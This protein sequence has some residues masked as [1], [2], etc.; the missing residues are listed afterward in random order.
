MAVSR[1][2][3][4]QITINN[5]DEHEINSDVINKI[6]KEISWQYYCFAYEIGEQEHTPHI[7]LYFVCTNAVSFDR[8]KKLF[9]C[10]HLEACKGTS[11][12][13]RNYIRKEGKHSD[14][15]ITNTEM[16]MFIELTTINTLLIITMVSQFYFLMNFTATF[17]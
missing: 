14:K 15:R 12:D 4:W 5:P 9:P 10:A 6:M 17:R 16:K 8:L 3:K 1:S 7:H 2:R 11:Q 13:N